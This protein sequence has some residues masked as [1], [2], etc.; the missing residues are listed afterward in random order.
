M[1]RKLTN[2]VS[3]LR[4]LAFTLVI[5]FGLVLIVGSGGGSGDVIDLVPD[6]VEP[7]LF[8]FG[9]DTGDMDGD[10]LIDI[11]VAGRVVAPDDPTT[12]HTDILLQDIRNPGTFLAPR[13]FPVHSLPEQ[14]KLADLNADMRLD[15]IVS[16]RYS[17]KSIDVLLH[18]SVNLAQLGA[19]MSYTTV[20]RPNQIATGDIDL[21]GLVDI[22]VAGEA[23]VAWHPQRASGSFTDREVIGA[24]VNTVAVADLDADGVLDVV[25]QDGTPD[26]IVLIYLQRQSMTGAFKPALSVLTDHSLW[27]LTVG[28]LDGDG[29]PDIAAAGFGAEDFSSFFGAWLP[30]LQ[31]SSNPPTFTLR[32]GFKTPP[33]SPYAIEIGDLNNDGRPDVVIGNSSVVEVYLRDNVPLLFRIDKNYALPINSNILA[34]SIAD[35]N[36]DLLPDIAASGDK[37]FVLFQKSGSPGRFGQPVQIQGRKP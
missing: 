34:V 26:G 16:H 18:D 17:A 31:T 3:A 6:P 25:S 24:G 13:R 27:T 35:L 14:L 28:E 30:I 33:S 1:L 8:S 23:S 11:V 7:T 2:P 10:G 12:G 20:S 37:V 36:N 15:V 9:L 32:Q 4:L 21:D 22:V 19:A 29:R 5:C